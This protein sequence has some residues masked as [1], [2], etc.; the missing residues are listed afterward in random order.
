MHFSAPIEKTNEVNGAS[1]SPL[2]LGRKAFIDTKYTLALM[3][4][5]DALKSDSQKSIRMDALLA[6]SFSTWRN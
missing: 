5:R 2:D 4:A 3:H 1:E 6:S